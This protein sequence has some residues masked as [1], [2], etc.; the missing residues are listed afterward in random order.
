MLSDSDASLLITESKVTELGQPFTGRMVLLDAE[1]PQISGESRENPRVQIDQEN[2]AYV[3]YTS[4]S[5]GRPKGVAICHRSAVAFLS[6]AQE[7]FSGQELKGV[8]ASTSICFDLS[9]FEI[10]VPLSCGGRVIV[11]ENALD[12]PGLSADSGITLVNTVPSAITELLR[13]NGVPET[14]RTVNLAGEAL[15]GSLVKQIYRQSNVELVR[16][17]YGPT[18]DTTYS[19]YARMRKDEADGN[20]TIGSPIA[21]TRAYVLD[22]EMGLAPVGVVGELY[23]GGNGLARGYLNRP[24]LTAERFVPDPF[25]ATAGGRLYSTGDL[26]RYRV[27]GQLDFLGRRDHQVKIR[28]F[29][30]ELGEIE[31]ALNDHEGVEDSLVMAREDASG[32]QSLVGYVVRA[33][34]A[35]VDGAELRRGL[36]QSLPEYMVP[37]SIMVLPSWPLTANGKLD[38]KALP[39]SGMADRA[40]A[41]VA[42]QNEMEKSIATL[43]Q[44]LLHMEKVG[45]F[46]NFFDLGGHSLLA[47]R[48]HAALRESTG[49]P[50]LLTDLFKYPTVAALAKRLTEGADQQKSGIAKDDADLRKLQLG[51]TRI[52]MRARRARAP[53]SI[54]EEL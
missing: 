52:E 21:S 48:V 42:P 37:S 13:T 15:Q 32:N 35:A 17:L 22:D 4:G 36:R 10:F 25:S 28:G 20:V 53:Q 19:T 41:F 5:T 3:I 45:I 2:L 7:V 8:L 18:E 49:Q 6:W 47:V 54:H 43:W 33:A 39:D 14:V 38:R 26:V 9:V 51:K 44:D 40:S 16:N 1:W 30:I 50:L 12:L 46:D 11:V 27:D 34:E 23:L 29:R 24:D 31:T